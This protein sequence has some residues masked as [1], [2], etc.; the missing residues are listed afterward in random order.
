MIRASS[1]IRGRSALL[2][3]LQY[4]SPRIHVAA[5]GAGRSFYA[6][7]KRNILMTATSTSRHFS[8]AAPIVVERQV[9]T[10]SPAQQEYQQLP[11]QPGTVTKKLRVLDDHIVQVIIQD[12]KSVD[13]N[14]DGRCVDTF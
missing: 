7:A 12:L 10:S 8:A 13:K 9:P 1:L 14:Q 5:L 2:V 6:A 4:G 3:K 11:R